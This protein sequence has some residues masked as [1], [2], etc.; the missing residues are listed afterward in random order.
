MPVYTDGQMIQGVMVRQARSAS[1]SKSGIDVRRHT[2][3]VDQAGE[4]PGNFCR[5]GELVDP[6]A[7][8]LVELE[9]GQE[10]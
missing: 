5:R 10:P 6:V 2:P 4:T 8:G 3:P 7:L 9:R 1:G